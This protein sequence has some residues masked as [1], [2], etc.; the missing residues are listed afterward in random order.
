M[1]AVQCRMIEQVLRDG[2]IEVQR[3]R[4]KH[5]AHAAQRLAGLALDIMA[6]NADTPGL[7]A[8]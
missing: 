6:E 4:L 1:D 8:E 3:A 2:E 5:H 7:H